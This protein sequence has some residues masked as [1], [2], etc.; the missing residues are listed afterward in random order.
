[1]KSDN[2]Q[3]YIS[4]QEATKM[5]SYSQEY[6]SLR[7]RQG[8]LKALKFCRNWVT[9][10]EWLEEYLVRSEEYNHSIENK[11]SEKKI[12]EIEIIKSLPPKNLP[13]ETFSIT[14]GLRLRSL[15]PAFSA[16][17]VFVL[18]IAGG[19]FGKES[20]IGTYRDFSPYVQEISRGGDWFIED[21]A[22]SLTKVFQNIQNF[23]D[24]FYLAAINYQG[25]AKFAS[26]VFGEYGQWLK[27]QIIK[28]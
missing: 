23:S 19:I 12:A 28:P 26:D 22:R 2:Y 15:R 18:L 24:D 3:D 4:L 21:S 27:N 11:K 6:L 17:L 10:K 16:A 9:T 25:T 7:A 20:L 14:E 13:V 5:C 8:K 1:M